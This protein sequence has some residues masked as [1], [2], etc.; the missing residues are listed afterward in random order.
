M[1]AACGLAQAPHAAGVVHLVALAR[2]EQR[3]DLP[4]AHRRATVFEQPRIA[5]AASEPFG[6][7]QCGQRI[8]ARQR[9]FV[10]A[11]DDARMHVVPE[12]LQ[13][14]IDLPQPVDIARQAAAFGPCERER[15]QHAQVAR[16]HAQLSCDAVYTRPVGRLGGDDGVAELLLA[17]ARGCLLERHEIGVVFQI[18]TTGKRALDGRLQ[19]IDLIRQQPRLP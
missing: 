17:L 10:R 9:V 11:I 2:I 5:H 3:L 6:F 4:Q 15:H 13:H 8:H 12:S 14:R 19:Q 16:A 7:G 1:C 18:F